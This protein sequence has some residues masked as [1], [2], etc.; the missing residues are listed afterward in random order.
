VAL[1]AALAGALED[2]DWRA[3][4]AVAKTWGEIA[5]AVRAPRN[6]DLGGAL[7]IEDDV[8]V[9]EAALSAAKS[10]RTG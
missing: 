4:A 2:K 6:A 3:V 5:G 8:T 10:R 1:E 7:P 9:L